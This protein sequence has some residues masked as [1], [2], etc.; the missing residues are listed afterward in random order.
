MSNYHTW[1]RSDWKR[2]GT[3]H[4]YNNQTCTVCGCT[5]RIQRTIGLIKY[6]YTHF[7]GKKLVNFRSRLEV[8]VRDNIPACTK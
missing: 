3:K 2:N 6:Y 1:S 4:E 7:N 5:R 8:A